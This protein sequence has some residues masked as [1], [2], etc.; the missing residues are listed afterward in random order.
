VSASQA[1]SKTLEIVTAG[2]VWLCPLLLVVSIAGP[3]HLDQVYRD[4]GLRDDQVRPDNPWVT[5]VYEGD[6]VVSY[7]R[8]GGG[9]GWPW[10]LIPLSGI[11]VFLWLIA[12][13]IRAYSAAERWGTMAVA[14][15]W[16]SLTAL[17]LLTATDVVPA[18]LG[19]GDWRS[20]GLE[21][22]HYQSQGG[23][24]MGRSGWGWGAGLA[25]WAAVGGLVAC[26]LDLSRAMLEARR[27][28]QSTTS[29]SRGGDHGSA[30]T[31][32]VRRHRVWRALA[33]GLDRPSSPR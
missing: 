11:L 31:I 30:A 6:G 22:F 29:G 14:A 1:A 2:L 13:Y 24:D 20:H 8:S 10:A 32:S 21:G 28:R 7:H 4:Q 17:V 25:W 26:L 9:A 15:G 18:S 19:L 12:G 3:W 5:E 23:V 33:R 27:E 16:F